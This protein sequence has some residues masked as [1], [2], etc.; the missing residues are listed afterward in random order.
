MKRKEFLAC[1]A[2]VAGGAVVPRFADAAPTMRPSWPEVPSGDERFWR[3]LR[4]QFPLTHDRVY[5]N[6]GGLGASPYSVID[7]VK[8][9]MDELEQLSEPGETEELWLSVKS[10]AAALL[11][12]DAR[13][14]AFMRNTTE[15][16]NVV[17]NGLPFKAGDEVILTTHEH[18]GGGLT[19]LPLAERK[20]LTVRRFEPSVASAA[21]NLSR[22]EKLLSRRTRLIAVPHI[23]TTTGLVMPVKE[24]CALAN[25]RG[26][27][28]FIDG[29][30]SAGMMPFSLHELGCDAYAT[31]G[32]KWLLG[33]K[34]TGLLYVRKEIQKTIVPLF[35]GAYSALYDFMKYTYSYVDEAKRYEYGTVSVP[36]RYGLGEAIRFIQRIGINEIWKRDRALA[37]RLYDGLRAI[38]GVTLL[39]SPDPGLRSAMISFTHDRLSYLEMQKHLETKYQMRTRGV[40][41]GGLAALRISMHVYTSDEEV[42]RVIE[43][44][45]A[46]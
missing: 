40:N 34:E 11:G 46:A 39:S 42:D 18:I 41:E 38:R 23:V 8:A 25:S 26:I 33:P 29:A 32:H 9:K 6:T 16:I 27:W 1:V 21:E 37:D 20:G 13:E 4:D 3:F 31:S 44:V 28:S 7:A 35:V 22:I 12:C 36:L 5:L 14:L 17:A 45:R 30:Q 10:C 24:I 15:G 19:W 43:G 2:G